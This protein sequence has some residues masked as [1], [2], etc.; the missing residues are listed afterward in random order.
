MAATS[1][2]PGFF[3][4]LKTLLE[5]RPGVIGPPRVTVSTGDLGTETPPLAIIIWGATAPREHVGLRGPQG[6]SQDETVVVTGAIW[7]Q[8]PGQG[9]TVI[10]AV[11]DQAAALLAEVETQLK[12]TPTMGGTC[13]YAT[14]TSSVWEAGA[15]DQ[16]RWQQISFELT[17]RARLV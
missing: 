10:A 12:E 8:Q 3:D 6:I 13:Q 5:L 14:V 4:N 2:V 1:S 7:V 11:R 9:E 15:N 17:Y 16:G